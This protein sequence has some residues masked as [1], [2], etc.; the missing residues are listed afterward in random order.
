MTEH[1]ADSDAPRN[2][3][4]GFEST[5]VRASA[6]LKFAVFLLLMTIAVLFLMFKMYQGFARYEAGLQPPRPIMQTQADRQPPLP[7]LQEHPTKDIAELRRSEDAI[8]GSY[9]WVDPQ[10]KVVRIPI[11]EAMRL[12]AERGLPVRGAEEPPPAPNSGGKKK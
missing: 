8:L 9:G 12:V 7:R 4:V 6:I 11:D 10:A 5:D 3:A 1:H 2:S